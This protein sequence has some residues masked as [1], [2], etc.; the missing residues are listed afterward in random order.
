MCIGF[1][2]IEGYG[3]IEGICGISCNLCGGECWLGLIGLCLLYC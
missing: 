2:V 3:F 1:K